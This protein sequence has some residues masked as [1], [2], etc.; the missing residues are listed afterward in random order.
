MTFRR[1]LFQ[2]HMYVGLT[3]GA[4][5]AMMGLSGATLVFESELERGLHPEVQ[6]VEPVGEPVPLSRVV[7]AVEQSQGGRTPNRV[8]IPKRP[9]APFEAWMDGHGE[10]RVYVHPYSG[11]VLGARTSRQLLTGTMHD[12][13]TTLLAGETGETVVGVCGLLL[14][15]LC[16]SGLVLWWPGRRK[17]AQ[18]FTVRRPLH[19]RRAFYDLHKLGGVLALVML[20]M[21][22][23]TGSAFVFPAAYEGVL[24]FITGTPPRGAAPKAGPAQGEPLP[25]DELLAVADGALPGARTTRVDLPGSPGKPLRV[26]K[27]FPEELHPNGMSYVYVDRYSGAVLRADS[28]REDTLTARVMALRYPLHTGAW[29]GLVTRL[30]AVLLGLFPAS[31]F[32]TGFLMW[33]ARVRPREAAAPQ[34]AP[35]LEP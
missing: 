7:E 14:I 1:L 11:A 34:P 8:K 27:R 33:L 29:G 2:V 15:G 21:N 25:L 30:L 17:L 22:G 24:Q 16:L 28:T 6:R 32:L 35:Q 3:V 19:G 23:L 20:L 5:L 31:L 26:R 9:D 10:Q 12:V 4:V 13:H 18:G